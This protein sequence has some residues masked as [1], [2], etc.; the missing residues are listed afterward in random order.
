MRVAGTQRV[1]PVPVQQRGQASVRF[2]ATV[3]T[4]D[5]RPREAQQGGTF[6]PP[7]S[8]A[9]PPPVGAVGPPPLDAAGPPPLGAAGSTRAPLAEPSQGRPSPVQPRRGR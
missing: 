4:P 5:T 7:V 2:P 3:A 6:A 8:A 9:G 1:Q